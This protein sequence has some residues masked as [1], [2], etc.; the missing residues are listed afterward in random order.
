[1]ATP[2]T[3]EHDGENCNGAEFC[4]TCQVQIFSGYKD[5]DERYCNDHKPATWDAEIAEMTEEEFDDQDEM[6]WTEWEIDDID[7][8]CP[9]DCPCRPAP[10]ALQALYD[11]DRARTEE[12]NKTYTIT[13]AQLVQIGDALS[14]SESLMEMDDLVEESRLEDVRKA[15]AVVDSV[16][17][18]KSPYKQE[19]SWCELCNDERLEEDLN[20]DG[21]CEPCAE[22]KERI[23]E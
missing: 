21:L 18:P 13:H 4:N 19:M 10:E 5:A 1:M 16:L 15:G 22:A 12:D 7:C 3:C 14:D 23:G 9:V 17:S 2:M 11:A 6:Y 20:E 8:D